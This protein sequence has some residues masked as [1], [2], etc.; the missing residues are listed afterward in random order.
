MDK[1]IWHSEEE[2]EIPPCAMP[3]FNKM[4]QDYK[5]WPKRADFPRYICEVMMRSIDIM[6]AMLPYL[7]QE[8]Q[9]EI[10]DTAIRSTFAKME[11]VSQEK[12]QEET[13]NAVH[14]HGLNG[15]S[16]ASDLMVRFNITKIE[17]SKP[18]RE[19]VEEHSKECFCNDCYSSRR[20][21]EDSSYG[22]YL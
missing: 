12:L 20:Y 14:K 1:L 10:S 17:D 16:A 6:N 4:V 9:S 8:T 2:S 5:E 19:S 18:V 13:R 11:M 3:D 7:K 22:R 15:I 21:K